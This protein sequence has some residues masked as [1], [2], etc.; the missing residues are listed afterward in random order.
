MESNTMMKSNAMMKETKTS[1]SVMETNS[2]V[3]SD[4][5]VEKTGAGLKVLALGL[6]LLFLG[7]GASDE[8]E[9]GKNG[10]EKNNKMNYEWLVGFQCNFFGDFCF[11][12]IFLSELTMVLILMESLVW[13]LTQDFVV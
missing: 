7:H 5:S 11:L 9:K 4:S 10:L 13:E 2:V 1:D 12:K 3:K 8:G 6:F